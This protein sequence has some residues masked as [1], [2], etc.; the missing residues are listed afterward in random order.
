MQLLLRRMREGRRR[1]RQRVR[2]R[3]VRQ[4]NAV[5]CGPACLAMVLTY[6]GRRTSV[7]ECRGLL[8]PGRDGV[9]AAQL[10]RAARGMG[11][12]GKAFAT[13]PESLSQLSLPLIAHW[14]FNHFVVLERWSEAGAT[15]VDP[16]Y[17]RKHV[18]SQ[19]FRERFTGVVLVF[20]RRRLAGATQ[21]ARSRSWTGLLSAMWNAPSIRRIVGG[22]V[23][24]SLA[25]QV[26]GL[27]LPLLTAVVVDAV[28]P[29]NSLGLLQIIGIGGGLIIIANLCLA[30]IRST[31]IV[32]LRARLDT[33]LMVGFL[34]HLLRLPF[35]FFQTRSTGDLLMR[36]S[37]NSVIREA[38]TTQTVSFFLDGSIVIGYALILMRR[39]PSLGIL[40]CGLGVLQTAIA[41]L[42]RN[43]VAD[44][45]QREYGARSDSQS[46]M[47]EIINNIALLK[48]TGSEDSV[49]QRWTRL[50]AVEIGVSSERGSFSAKYEVS[51]GL[52]RIGGPVALLL[53]GAA[54]VVSGHMGLGTMLGLNALAVAFLFP[55]SN[56]VASVQQLQNVRVH[57]ERIVDVLSARQ[58]EQHERAGMIPR[59][60][61]RICAH[62][63]SFRY[64]PE[65][66]L[67]LK[68][69]SFEIRAG[70]KVAIVGPSGSGKSTLGLLLLGLHVR[71]SGS[72]VFDD[73]S[74]DD[75]NLTH[76]RRQFGVVLQEPTLFGGSIR[77][78]LALHDDAAPLDA[79]VR[80]T[81]C[82]DIHNEICAMPLG[83]ETLLDESGTNLSGGQ[84]Q[85]LAIARALTTQ[86]T[87]LLLDEATSHLDVVT[88]ARVD[89]QLS[90]LTCTRIVIAHRLS[91]VRNADLVLVLNE[92]RL[93]EQGTHESLLG[94]E[95]WYA[96]L[97]GHQTDT[98]RRLQV[99]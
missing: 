82:A 86:P 13:E 34:K 95:K 33:V 72:L 42:A 43:R 71:E 4:L 68:S 40:A 11:L 59:L 37:S 53:L 3:V 55:L 48:A 94:A 85:R 69:V 25:L 31:C 27:L 58:E 15:I 45:L 24:T 99:F 30:Y 47:V 90:Q 19:E 77:Q 93:V 14:D 20:S 83:Y 32:L 38:F 76:L 60:S 52:M 92:G 41:F 88:E 91:T 81:K 2:V 87:F 17:G 54:Q 26:F 50:F 28:I 16:A 8:Q 73:I 79:L 63:L 12:S 49:F 66:P 22:L 29:R 21:P 9:N 57:L 89:R 64:S 98:N 78:N 5:E 35:G 23:V 65:G 62:D 51:M 96:S 80:A 39:S 97:V 74:I 6:L 67:V 84:R 1:G 18:K 75:I 10:L 56:L 70:Q 44:L 36:L 46:Y 7:Q 61:G